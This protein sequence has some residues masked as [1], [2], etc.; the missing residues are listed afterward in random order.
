[1]FAT[2]VRA[3]ALVALGFLGVL[4]LFSSSSYGT[5]TVESNIYS[6]GVGMF[7]F[8][9]LNI[10]LAVAGFALMCKK[11]ATPVATQL[12]RPVFNYFFAFVL[13]MACHVLVG[14][15]LGI[16]L[17]RILGQ[18]GFINL[19]FGMIF[20]YLVIE[21]FKN[22]GDQ[23]KL[24]LII[25]ALASIRCVFGLIRYAWFGGDVA[26]PYKNLDNFD[27]KLVFFDIGDNYV[28][29]LGAFCAAWLLMTTQLK[30]S[31]I[32]RFAL[33][34]LFVLMVAAVALSF[35]RSS[36][37]GLVL[38][39]T[40]LVFRLPTKQ[41][42]IFILF[43][44]GFI[45]AIAVIFFRQRLQFAAG[46]GPGQTS[47]LS[48]LIFD[49]SPTRSLENNRF[50]ELYAAAISLGKNWPIGLGSWGTFTGDEE[51]LE[52]HNGLFD[53]IHSGFGHIML[54]TGAIGL[55]LFCGLLFAYTRHYLRTRKYLTGTSLLI[56]D[57]G[58]A[59]FLFWIPT[60]LIGTPLIEFR[61][62][63]LFGLTLAMP[64]VATRLESQKVY[65]Y[66]EA[67]NRYSVA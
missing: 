23:E 2:V 8:S 37:V 10:G 41:R 13:L 36:L 24:L 59:G 29:S 28:V 12:A 56:A 14:L 30:I 64:F 34:G 19:L 45:S 48:S 16:E 35:R 11:L 63:M 51:L 26:N 9:L 38:M 20:M 21:S 46:D 43:S 6:R 49:I 33:F 22:N 1:V 65:N 67:G 50:Y 17:E 18:N 57:A 44:A 52:Y 5:L 42:F 25:L 32:S 62:M 54:K 31:A 58:F 55:I 15:M 66:T 4:F 40:L 39:C 3:P 27:I 61:T 53:F 7:N 60:L 47:I